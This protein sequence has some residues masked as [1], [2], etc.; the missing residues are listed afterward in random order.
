MPIA[1]CPGC[2]SRFKVPDHAAGKRIK[3][4]KCAG[5]ISV[6]AVEQAA[7]SAKP[8]V[9]ATSPPVKSEQRW[10]LKTAAN[11]QFGPVPRSQLDAWVAAGSVNAD[12]QLLREGDPQWQWADTIY[13]R[14]ATVPASAAP[15]AKSNATIPDPLASRRQAVPQVAAQ[16]DDADEDEFDDDESDDLEPLLTPI[17][18]PGGFAAIVGSLTGV[19][20]SMVSR[21]MQSEAK[22]SKRSLRV[23]QRQWYQIGDARSWREQVS[24]GAMLGWYAERASNPDLLDTLQLNDARGTVHVLMP[25]DNGQ[26]EPCEL[27]SILPGRLP[28]SVALVRGEGGN[29][30]FEAAGRARPFLAAPV[31]KMLEVAGS[32]QPGC[33]WS[34]LNE[35]GEHPLS[36]ALE[37]NRKLKEGVRFDGKLNL[38]QISILHKLSWFAQA[39]PLDEQAFL[40]VAQLVPKNKMLMGLD[41]SLEWYLAWREEFLKTVAAVPALPPEDG[42]FIDP[43]LW[44]SYSRE[45]LGIDL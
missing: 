31:S 2:Q 39:I 37:A 4:P 23:G 42:Q 11:E 19:K 36:A 21:C 15:T 34:A 43:G 28:V 35:P 40:L 20:D 41:C 24:S 30:G 26:P 6:P 5:A 14:L 12:C 38:G 32:G 9:V 1:D 33:G 13:L 10:Y 27:I 25:H 8:P 22:S 45:V 3:C 16:V 18:S 44:Y 17:A 7:T 29:W